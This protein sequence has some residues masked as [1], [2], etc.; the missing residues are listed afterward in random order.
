LKVFADPLNQLPIITFWLLGG[1]HRITADALFM[2]LWPI[3]L[4]C[5]VLFALRWQV[6]ALAAGDDEARALGINVT[7]FRLLLILVAT[8]ITTTCVSI[9]GIV[10]WVGLLIPTSCGCWSVQRIL[11]C[12]RCALW[13]EAAI[14]WLWTTSVAPPLP[15][16]SRW[17]S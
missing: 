4:P 8:L 15:Q 7:R 13:W 2:A 11:S 5:A 6:H 16:R 12:S 14:S 9:S 17:A 3:M 10:S 1:L